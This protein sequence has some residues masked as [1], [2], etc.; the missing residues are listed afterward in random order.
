[1]LA[2][3]AL[4]GLGLVA[5]GLDGGPALVLGVAVAVALAVA[6]ALGGFVTTTTPESSA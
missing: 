1:M 5:A 6:L 3:A 2:Q 4:A